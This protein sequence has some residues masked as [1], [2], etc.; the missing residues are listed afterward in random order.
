MSSNSQTLDDRSLLQRYAQSRDADAFAELA[1]RYAGLVYATCLRV[2][3]NPDDAED[4]SQECFLELAR[5]AGAIRSC[6]PAWLHRVARNRSVDSIRRASA[7]RSRE[8]A[9]AAPDPA[10]SDPTWADLEPHVDEAVERLPERLREAVIL[11]YIQGRGQS[12]VASA[13]DVSQS[14]VSRRLDLA[15]ES[16]RAELRKAGVIA[17]AAAIAGLLAENSSAAAP[18]SLMAVLG[19]I[20]ISGIGAAAP[21]GVTASALGTVKGFLATLGGKCVVGGLVVVVGGSVGYRTTTR[22]SDANA[23][24]SSA[25]VPNAAVIAQAMRIQEE[26]CGPSLEVLYTVDIG[27]QPPDQPQRRYVRHY[28]RTPDVLWVEN[29]TEKLNPGA[30]GWVMR[31]ETMY[32]YNKR[33]R[34]LREVIYDTGGA[35]VRE[36]RESNGVAPGLVPGLTQLN[37][38]ETV[39]RYLGGERPLYET[40]NSGIVAAEL[41]SV[42]GH[43]CWKVEI[44]KASDGTHYTIW[45]D[46]EIGFCPRRID[47]MVSD[48]VY[49]RISQSDYR[50]LSRGVWFPMRQEAVGGNPLGRT[51]TICYVTEAAAGRAIP[52]EEVAVAFPP[53]TRIIGDKAGTGVP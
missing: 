43:R 29:R 39:A 45:V 23:S 34:E 32:S 35:P 19:K 42:D 8:R 33:S 31:D 10:G 13:L 48:R 46:P 6:L 36:G 38:V 12:D 3:R 41:E 1:R 9:A 14:T 15:V 52:A 53:D 37:F 51:R 22:H 26:A 5:K 25:A 17:S 47:C 24:R 49:A 2:T 27:N 40:V 11:H 21:S 7:R 44:P 20:A 4:L 28:I 50:S 16:L 30:G 18:A